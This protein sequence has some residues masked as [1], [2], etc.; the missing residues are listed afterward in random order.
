MNIKIENISCNK[1]TG[2]AGFFILYSA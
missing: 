1:K 2:F